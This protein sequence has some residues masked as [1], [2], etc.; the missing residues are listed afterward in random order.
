MRPK[1]TS[2]PVFGPDQGPN[3]IPIDHVSPQDADQRV[4]CGV[5]LSLRGRAIRMLRQ[6][7]M[8]RLRDLTAKP[9]HRLI[10]RYVE[11]RNSNQDQRA[12]AAV[13]AWAPVGGA[14]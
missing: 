12:V 5:A 11:A 6:T 14:Q 10:V 2:I 9:N 8:P 4:A 7:T 1:L 3:E 13:Q